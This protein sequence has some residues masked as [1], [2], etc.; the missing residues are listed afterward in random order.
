MNDRLWQRLS[1]NVAR[2][3]A[4]LAAVGVVVAFSACA[5]KAATAP[6]PPAINVVQV[7]RGNVPIFQEFI[8][9]TEAPNNVEIRARVEGYVEKI[10]FTEG[11]VVRAGTLLYTLDPRPF[12]AALESARADLAKAQAQLA[13]ARDNVE[14][15][16]AQANLVA[17]EAELLNAQQN[18]NHVQPLASQK[19]VTQAQ[20][21]AASARQKEA[22]AQVDAGKAAVQQAQVTQRTDID[23]A[24][25][26]VDAANAAIKTAEL[27]LGYTRIYSPITGRIGRTSVNP[28]SLVQATMAEPLT[29]ISTTGDVYVNFTIT[30]REYLAFA[31]KLREV[32]AADPNRVG[33]LELILADG[34]VHTHRGRV[35]LA[36]RTVDP[37]TGTLGLRAVFPN[38]EGTIRPGQFARIRTVVEE[39]RD[40]ILLPQAAVMD[41]LG[42]RYVYIVTNEDVVARRDVVPGAQVGPNYVIDKGLEPG[43]R[44]VIEGLQKVRPDVKVTPRVVPLPVV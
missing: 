11:S 5:K 36:D 40:V 4:A 39:A 9:Q 3:V 2:P 21:D 23:A 32:E 15:V 28:G 6:E 44:V 19:A 35:N 34:S 17:Y 33:A 13:K 7:S 25:G 14:L 31:Q 20:L 18:L 38:P 26:T 8:G 10:L 41:Q 24:R 42:S 29:V 1:L 37:Q 27:N 30:E 16:Q 43:E 22:Q 12:Q